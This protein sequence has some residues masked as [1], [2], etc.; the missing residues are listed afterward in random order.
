MIFI[1]SY[2]AFLNRSAYIYEFV[3][4]TLQSL[5]SSLLDFR[6]YEIKAQGNNEMTLNRSK[7]HHKATTPKLY[8]ITA[9]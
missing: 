5:V 4:Y 1:P 3:G 7:L 2:V 9:N 8:E 6:I